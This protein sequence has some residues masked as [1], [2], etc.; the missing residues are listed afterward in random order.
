MPPAPAGAAEFA[1][2]LFVFA[3]QPVSTAFAK[4][5]YKTCHVCLFPA[6][7]LSLGGRCVWSHTYINAQPLTWVNYHLKQ[8]EWTGTVTG[9]DWIIQST[10]AALGCMGLAC[11]NALEHAGSIQPSPGPKPWK[12][13]LASPF[14]APK[15]PKFESLV[16]ITQGTA[17]YPGE[18]GQGLRLKSRTHKL[19]KQLISCC[20][21]L[22]RQ[23][24]LAAGQGSNPLHPFCMTYT[25]CVIGF[26]SRQSRECRM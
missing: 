22:H 2:V 13:A 9:P 16:C 4:Y 18:A 12:G 14:Q 11:T 17:T 1:G 20:N 5:A 10:C 7:H 3:F 25:L 24:C 21:H 23:C 8:K 26:L 6:L 19:S 15:A